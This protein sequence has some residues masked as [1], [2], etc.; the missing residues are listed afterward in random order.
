MPLLLWLEPNSGT[1]IGYND[2]DDSCVSQIKRRLVRYIDL[3][4]N[5]VNRVI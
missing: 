5:F 3:F 4:L 1:Y 2:D